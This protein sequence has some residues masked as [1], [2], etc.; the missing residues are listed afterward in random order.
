[1]GTVVQNQKQR[2]LVFV[3]VRLSARNPGRNVRTQGAGDTSRWLE[4]HWQPS[5]ESESRPL[6]VHEFLRLEGAFAFNTTN[7]KYDHPIRSPM[8]PAF[9]FSQGLDLP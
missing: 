1:M 9:P 6:R 8:G 4:P 5:R 3:Y 2:L 7:V